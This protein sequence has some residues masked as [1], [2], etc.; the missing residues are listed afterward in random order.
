MIVA[1]SGYGQ[2]EDRRQSKEAGFDH[3]LI[4]P[5]NYDALLALLAARP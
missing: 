4:K 2:N 3:H 5:L 1:I